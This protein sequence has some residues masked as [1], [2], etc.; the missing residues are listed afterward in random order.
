MSEKERFGRY[1]IIRRL[2]GGMSDVYLAQDLVLS[3]P[4]V[5]KIVRNSSGVSTH[6]IIE[7]E[8]RG[9]CIQRQLAG[10]PRILQVYESGELDGSF[11]IAMSIFP[12]AR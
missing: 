8:K 5:L 2:G 6:L 7:A 12:A 4:V 1:E 9:V 10:Q 11:F 3:R